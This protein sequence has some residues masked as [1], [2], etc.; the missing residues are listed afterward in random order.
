MTTTAPRVGGP[1][2][3]DASP[4]ERQRGGDEA[5]L[6][7]VYRRHASV[8]FNVAMRVTRNRSAA[9]EVTQ[10]VFLDVWHRPQRFDSAR[11]HLG[12][13][14]ATM[15]HHRSVDWVR[16]ETARRREHRHRESDVAHLRDVEETVA[17]AMGARGGPARPRRHV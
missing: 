6:A 4:H 17:A 7:D 11:G 5:A 9:E 2:G 12:S 13:W 10:G 1:V 8:V 15:A 3:P 14:L 16:E